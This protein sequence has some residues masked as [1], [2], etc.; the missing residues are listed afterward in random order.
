MFDGIR[1]ALQLDAAPRRDDAVYRAA[2]FVLYAVDDGSV[3][4]AVQPVQRRGARRLG[5]ALVGQKPH[6]NLVFCLVVYENIM[7]I[8]YQSITILCYPVGNGINSAFREDFRQTNAGNEQS[9]R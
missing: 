7:K 6:K 2:G 5:Q 1:K 4:Y 9:N 3:L 8:G